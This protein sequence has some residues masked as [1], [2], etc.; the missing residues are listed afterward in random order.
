MAEAAL[1]FLLGELRDTLKWYNDLLS[2]SQADFDLLNRE[3]N[4]MKTFLSDAASRREEKMFKE[5]EQ[6]IRD[7]VY[8]VED[9]IDKWLTAAKGKT[10]VGRF[11]KKKFSLAKE[12]KS[13]RDD[14][15]QPVLNLIRDNFAALSSTPTPAPDQH[16][17]RPKKVN[18]HLISLSIYFVA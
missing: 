9:T 1:T 3:L 14:R 18:S 12:V 17:S 7:V 2:G 15:V 8:E 13:L 5:I 6:Q 10:T 16:P 11:T 4:L